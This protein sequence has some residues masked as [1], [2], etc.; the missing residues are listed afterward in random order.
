EL[1]HVRPG[2]HRVLPGHSRRKPD[3]QRHRGGAQ[4]AHVA[5]G[6]DGDLHRA[7]DQLGHG[8]DLKGR[9]VAAQVRLGPAEV[10]RGRG[11]GGGE[12]RV[13]PVVGWLGVWWFAAVW[14]CPTTPPL[15]PHPPMLTRRTFLST[16]ATLLAGS[17]LL[18]D[19]ARPKLKKAVKYG[20]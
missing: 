14:P 15:P 7:E 18:A 20:M 2:A 1:G 5:D 11:A 19:D 6:P 16:S 10:R 9:P 3:Q 4:H 17:A 8:D 13:I 12:F